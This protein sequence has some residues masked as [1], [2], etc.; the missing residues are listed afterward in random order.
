MPAY[1]HTHKD[2]EMH[3][4]ILATALETDARL[5]GLILQ[6]RLMSSSC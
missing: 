2:A 6:E 1:T 3:E 5:S 4:E